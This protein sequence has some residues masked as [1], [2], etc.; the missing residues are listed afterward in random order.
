[1]TQNRKW[2]QKR[3]V[4]AKTTT[5]VFLYVLPGIKADLA[6]AIRS[7]VGLESFPTLSYEMWDKE[8]DS[9]YAEL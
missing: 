6:V 9:K 5:R 1:M 7:W 4:E 2:P 3:F 8:G